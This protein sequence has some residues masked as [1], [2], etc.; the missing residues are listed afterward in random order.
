MEKLQVVIEVDAAK[1]TAVVKGVGDSFA[2]L[3]KKAG[4]LAGEYGKVAKH[5]TLCHAWL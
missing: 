3:Q 5:P 1:G 2:D 4:A